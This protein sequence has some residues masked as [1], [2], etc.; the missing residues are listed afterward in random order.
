MH[1]LSKILLTLSIITA[2]FLPTATRAG[3]LPACSATGACQVCDI[4]TVFVTLG[5]WLMISAGGLALLVITWAAFVLVASAGNPEKITGAKKQITGA[6]LGVGITLA[7][8]QL[9]SL[10]IATL[11]VPSSNKSFAGQTSEETGK[12]ASLSDF[13]G[14]PWWNIC[15]VKELRKL[16]ASKQTDITY[17]GTG[18]CR[19]WGDGTP[20]Q[21]VSEE[22]EKKLIEC[23][24]LEG[25]ADLTPEEKEKQ[26]EECK[27]LQK[28]IVRCCQGACTDKE[29]ITEKIAQPITQSSTAYRDQATMLT[30][31][32]GPTICR[33]NPERTSNTSCGLSTPADETRVRTRLRE[34]NMNVNNNACPARTC[35]QDIKQDTGRSCT[36]VGGL[37]DYAIATLIQANNLCN[38]CLTVTGGNECGHA[39]HGPPNVVDIDYSSAALNAITRS[40]VGLK[41]SCPN[42]FQ[43]G[44]TCEPVSK[45][46]CRQPTGCPSGTEWLHVEF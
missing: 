33:T 2:L 18:V 15:N 3:I 39:S 32:S 42:A 45:H 8:F 23:G 29:C 19:Y 38:D 37:S 12:F 20:C 46:D 31:P 36:T 44:Y 43:T 11:A 26:K 22:T 10:L 5:K 27:S 40:G 13:L 25:N 6:I 24:Y 35:Y 4:V 21:E 41:K 14:I 17:K 9:V 30:T 16:G 28:G 1:F 34:N 7:A